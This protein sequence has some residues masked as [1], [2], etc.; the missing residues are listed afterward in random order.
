MQPVSDEL[1]AAR[2]HYRSRVIPPKALEI[3]DAETARLKTDNALSRMLRPGRMA[4]NFA[5]PDVNGRLIT[6]RSKLEEGK[7]VIVFY[8]GGWCPYCNIQLRGMERVRERMKRTGSS[9]IAISPQLPDGSLTT[10]GKNH[11]NFDVLSDVGNHV[12][13]QFGIVFRLGPEL[14]DLYR[15]FGHGLETVNGG[16]GRGE[17]PVPSVFVVNEDRRIALAHADIDY[18]RRLEPEILA[19]FLESVSQ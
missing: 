2:E 16:S 6:L 12:A 8:R 13:R 17:L 3:M 1:S 10:Q 5:L 9:L 7:A 18:T 11:L 4:P 19:D 14:V 15:E